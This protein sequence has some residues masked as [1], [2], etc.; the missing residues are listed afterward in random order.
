M[1]L[2]ADLVETSS[3][4]ASTRA[5]SA[6]IAALAETLA[7]LATDEIVPAVAFLTGELHQGKI[8]VGWRTAFRADV[9]AADDPTLT[10]LDV[11]AAIDRLQAMIGPGS[12]GARQAELTSLFS[13]AT[14]EE[15]EFVRRLLVGE[16]RQGAL[17]GVM[18]DALARASGVPLA[19]VRRASM[20]A[21]DLCAV[22]VAAPGGGEDAVAA[23]DLEVLRPVS[24]MLAST[25][26][27]VAEAVGGI[28]ECSIEWKLDGARVQAHRLGDEVRLFTRNLNDITE[29]LPTVADVVRSFAVD[30]LILDGEVIGWGD[31]DGRQPDAFQET[32]SRFGRHRGDAERGLVVRFF[33]CLHVDGRTLI[34]APLSE[35]LDVLDRVVG[36]WRI[37]NV[38]TDDAKAASEFLDGALAAG[39]EGVMVKGIGSAYEAGRRGGSWKKVKPVITLDLLV[40]GAEWGHG[41]RTGWLSNLWLGARDP[42]GG[43]FVMVG[44]TFK[45]LT[46]ELLR[47]QTE[48]FLELEE[49]RDGIV[50]FIRPEVV[51]EVAIDGVQASPRYA[52]G[53]AL[54]F[55][56]VRRYRDDKAAAETDTIE[57]VRSLLH[58]RQRRSGAED[59]R[60]VEGNADA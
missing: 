34:D 6:K 31:D 36:G 43:P 26:T 32:M 27:D 55:A 49:S 40:L 46:D 37:P 4:V 35:R 38:V 5:R 3:R 7:K 45:G 51:V 16:L 54:R 42:A 17:E 1:T 14:S 19:A 8:G 33:D 53:V 47:W 30:S 21:G 13:R 59:G 10:V 22:A 15:Q 23:I 12:V 48:R 11:D 60:G 28:G 24:P 18:A 56:R 57:T 58:D 52:G 25:A 2:L 9:P 41:R 29:R 39:H 44:K 20:L 50:V